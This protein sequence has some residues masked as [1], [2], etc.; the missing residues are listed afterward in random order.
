MPYFCSLFREDQERVMQEMMPVCK[1]MMSSMNMDMSSMMSMMM[2][3][4]QK[5]SQ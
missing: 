4:M 2:N 5:P 1:E 3:M